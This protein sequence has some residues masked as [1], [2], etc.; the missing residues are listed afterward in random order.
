[1]GES[2]T[3]F[4]ELQTGVTGLLGAGI[5]VTAVMLSRFVGVQFQFRPIMYAG[6][7]VSNA[8][9]PAT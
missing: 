6:E 9:P 1:M 2:T 4:S 5:P 7:H 8:M 3:C